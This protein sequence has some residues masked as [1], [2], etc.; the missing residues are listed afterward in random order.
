[1]PVSC[2]ESETK[3]GPKNPHPAAVFVFLSTAMAALTSGG[4]GGGN[5]S[6]GGAASRGAS[7]SASAQNNT[8]S[9]NWKSDGAEETVKT[10]RNALRVIVQKLRSFWPADTEMR[11]AERAALL[12][13]GV[14]G[15]TTSK[16]SYVQRLQRDLSMLSTR[17][18]LERETMRVQAQQAGELFA[19][20]AQEDA[21]Q[22]EVPW[23][24]T[25]DVKAK[26][27]QKVYSMEKKHSNKFHL[28]KLTDRL[29]PHELKMKLSPHEL[30][31]MDL[32][33]HFKTQHNLR[34]KGPFDLKRLNEI[35]DQLDKLQGMS[36]LRAS[37]RIAPTRDSVDKQNERTQQIAS[38]MS[39]RLRKLNSERP[40]ALAQMSRTLERDGP[41][42]E[43]RAPPELTVLV[44]EHRAASAVADEP[45]R[46]RARI[47]QEGTGG[48]SAAE[49]GDRMPGV[50]ADGR[51]RPY[52]SAGG[53]FVASVREFHLQA[54]I[55]VR[56]KGYT[57]SDAPKD[58]AESTDL[59]LQGALAQAQVPQS[60]QVAREQVT[61][62]TLTVQ[63]P[64]FLPPSPLPPDYFA[65]EPKVVGSE[66]AARGAGCVLRQHQGTYGADGAIREHE[67]AIQVA[68][69][70]FAPAR[71][72]GQEAA[73]RSHEIE[74]DACSTCL[75]RF[76]LLVKVSPDCLLDTE[77]LLAGSAQVWQQEPGGWLQYVVEGV[78]RHLT[79]LDLVTKEMRSLHAAHPGLLS[80]CISGPSNHFGPRKAGLS[81]R[82]TCSAGS[83][84]LNVGIVVTVLPGVSASG[85]DGYPHVEPVW[86]LS[87]LSPG[88]QSHQLLREAFQHALSQAPAPLSMTDLVTTLLD[89]CG[90]HLGR[91]F[92]SI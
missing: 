15:V 26:F 68:A 81:V 13:R 70:A 43:P 47:H 88:L 89:T 8:G 6:S 33:K 30:K 75:R 45:A 36:A 87:G 59:P 53:M 69:F 83:V 74:W 22:G 54:V 61:R 51:V 78:F 55:N 67:L 73:S 5:A 46:K 84:P 10:R 24:A 35:D 17:K 25:A 23:N 3:R 18:E 76:P 40:F 16:A 92:E 79:C 2:V 1:M 72:R 9:S 90:R 52:C 80:S 82:W 31:M 85:R 62:A 57:D 77:T 42:L 71:A 11:L 66:V 48:A 14:Y 63:H 20:A 29:S 34:E 49:N 28:L 44:D 60:W 32:L 58:S 4:M 12:E 19:Q 86:H 56:G 7:T 50:T 27:V 64:A 39:E 41:S 37:A 65:A 91:E 38:R 21:K